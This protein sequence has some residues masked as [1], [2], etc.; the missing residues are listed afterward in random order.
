MHNDGHADTR[1]ATPTLQLVSTGW[2]PCPNFTA[3]AAASPV[4]AGCGWLAVEHDP[5]LPLAS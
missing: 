1:N 5:S 4:C 2:E 3:E